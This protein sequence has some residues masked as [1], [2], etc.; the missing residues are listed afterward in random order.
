MGDFFTSQKTEPPVLT[1]LGFVFMLLALFIV[2]YSASRFYKQ[3]SFQVFFRGLQIIQLVLLYGWY[4]VTQAPLSES[5]PFYHCRIAMFAV[6]LLP[7]RSSYKQ[8]FA[9]LGI[10]GPICALLHP[11]FDPYPLPHITMFSYLV[12]HLALLGNS[13]VYLMN[14]YDYRSLTYRRI[15]EITVGM[16]GVIF[17]VNQLTGGDYGFLKNPPLVGDYGMLCN[18][19]L[20]SAVLAVAL[21]GFSF[22]FKRLKDAQENRM[23]LLKDWRK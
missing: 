21:C 17:L 5:L 6:L 9:L 22:L 19:L 23:L 13:I 1:P 15:I 3:K 8:Y 14:E 12:G 20:V 16:N 2:I 7:K 10:F 4:I 11:I 18:F